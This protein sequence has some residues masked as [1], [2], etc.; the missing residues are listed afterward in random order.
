MGI[1]EFF[2]RSPHTQIDAPLMVNVFK[3]DRFKGTSGIEVTT[4]LPNTEGIVPLNVTLHEGDIDDDE[5]NDD[6]SKGDDIMADDNPKDVSQ[7]DELFAG[8]ANTRAWDT[9]LKRTYDE[10]QQVSLDHIRNTNQISER[11]LS[12]AATAS[13][14][15]TAQTIKHTSDTDAQK[16][17]HADIAIENQWESGAEVAG[18]AVVAALAAAVAKIL[19]NDD[20]E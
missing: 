5:L 11:I 8:D 2:A 17:R 1:K 9:N 12:D 10:Y 14:Q 19:S 15:I 13:A 20:G 4:G 3:G 18:E 7:G 6:S 16:V